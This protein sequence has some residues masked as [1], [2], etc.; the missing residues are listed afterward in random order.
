MGIKLIEGLAALSWAAGTFESEGTVTITRSGRRGYTRPLVALTSTDPEMILQ[1]QARWPGILKK[2]QPKG[3][4]K[5]AHTWTL[6][7]RP[8]IARFLWDIMPFLRTDRVRRK[9]QLVLDDI[10]ARV[11]GARG[12]Q[13]ISECHERREEIRDLNRRGVEIAPADPFKGGR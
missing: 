7:V 11:Q 2:H 10:G 3:N 12:Q 6:G 9:A 5:P 8:S 4:S 1:F 13:Y